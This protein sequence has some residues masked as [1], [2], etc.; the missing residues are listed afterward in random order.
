[1]PN[2]ETIYATLALIT[3]GIIQLLIDNRNIDEKAAGELLYN[4]KLYGKLENEET[5]LWRLSP[6]TLYDLLYEELTTG[7]ITWTEEQ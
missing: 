3:P 7:K 5:K 2:Q 6:L 4:S 1:M